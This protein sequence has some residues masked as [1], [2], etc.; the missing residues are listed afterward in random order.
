MKAYV[1]AKFEDK[2]RA[3]YAQRQLREL[4]YTITCDWTSNDDT[5]LVGEAKQKYW[6][7]SAL[8][9]LAGARDSDLLFL[10]THPNGRGSMTELGAAAVMN[11][12][13]IIVNPQLCVNVFFHLPWVHHVQ[14][15]DEGIAI[16]KELANNSAFESH[17][18]SMQ[19]SPLTLASTAQVLLEV[20]WERIRQD[21]K[22]GEQNHP[23][24]TGGAVFEA[25]RDY[26]R[27][28][29]DQAAKD[30]RLTFAHI[31]QEE[32][33]EAMA[34]SDEAKLEAELL[35]DAAVKI[36][37]IECIRRRRMKRLAV[38]REVESVPLRAANEGNS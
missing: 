11:R 9:D 7:Q 6:T 36:E 10:I 2:E 30:G 32:H 37:W 25:Q 31:S 17:G 29:C 26:M 8:E 33:Y 24:G 28:Q 19:F 4:G 15:I 16:A 27:R 1:A 14:S 13:I 20:A 21:A 18:I 35:Q 3:R 38:A 5:G 34:E 12:Q 23:D 22:W